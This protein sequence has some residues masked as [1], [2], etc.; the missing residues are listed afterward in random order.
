MLGGNMG[1]RIRIFRWHC[2]PVAASLG[3]SL[4][5]SSIYETAAWG[6][7]DQPAFLNQVLRR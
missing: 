7:A 6:K 1:D 3:I 4:L 5:A 2:L